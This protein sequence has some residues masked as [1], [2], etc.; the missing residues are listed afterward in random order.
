M[1]SADLDD[2][3]ERCLL[4][5]REEGQSE[6]STDEGDRAFAAL[7]RAVDLPAPRHDFASRAIRAARL[8]PLAT[9]RRALVS[10]ST[11]VAQFSAGALALLVGAA[12]SA[13]AF[14]P[15]V[16]GVLAAYFSAV[17]AAGF[18]V[19]QLVKGGVDVWT[20]SAGPGRAFAVLLQT[21][22]GATALVLTA[23]VS[24]LGVMG[25]ERLV[26]SEEES[27]PC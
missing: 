19:V 12:A 14:E 13:L 26:R 16:T 15:L 10:R 9:G 27:F 23:L 25:L 24:L 3:V 21:G 18:S 5:A 1:G 20:W 4:A 22:A 6:G 11:R 17:V 7:F 8:A 2:L